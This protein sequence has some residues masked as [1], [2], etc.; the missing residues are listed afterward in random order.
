MT[1]LIFSMADSV[2][3]RP[4]VQ[5]V[6]VM[7]LCFIASS[8][9]KLPKKPFRANLVAMYGRAYGEHILPAKFNNIRMI[10]SSKQ[11]LE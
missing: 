1:H 3:I 11:I 4:R 7:F 9:C 8:C 6:T 2:S 5:R 10:A